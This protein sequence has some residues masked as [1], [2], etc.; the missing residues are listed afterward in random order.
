MTTKPL[1]YAKVLGL[2]SKGQI[3][4]PSWRVFLSSTQSGNWRTSASIWSTVNDLPKKRNRNG[5][6]RAA[7]CQNS[8]SFAH[9]IVIHLPRHLESPLSEPFHVV[10]CERHV[11]A[12]SIL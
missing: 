6:L 10:S 12:E 3:K 8:S 5:V 9:W 11:K 2:T 7:T 1:R 4:S